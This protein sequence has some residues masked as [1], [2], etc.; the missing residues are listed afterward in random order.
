MSIRDYND[1][2]VPLCER[3]WIEEN[4]VWEPESVD[5]EGNILTRLVSVN[6]PIKLSPGTV[7]ECF[8]CSK[9]TVVGIYV[10]ADDIE[11]PDMDMEMDMDEENVLPFDEI[12]PE[13]NP[14]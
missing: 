8:I 10:S 3:C 4:S 14:A 12:P 13:D 9:V 7:C 2:L 1:D 5:M 6:V 11:E